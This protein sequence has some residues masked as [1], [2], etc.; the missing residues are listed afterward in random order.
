M[1]CEL[2][3]DHVYYCLFQICSQL[4]TR[5]EKQQASTKE[6]L[7]IVK[8]KY[9][10]KY[11]IQYSHL[12]RTLKFLLK[13]SLCF[14]Q[15]FSN[16]SILSKHVRSHVQSTA[17]KCKVSLSFRWRVVENTLWDSELQEPQWWKMNW[18]S[19]HANYKQLTNQTEDICLL[20]VFSYVLCHELFF[21]LCRMFQIIFTSV[22]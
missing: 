22:L 3:A 8:V 4:S 15:I 16:S 7:D 13:W 1:M 14:C 12:G 19:L 18:F 6:E 11:F 21:C 10:V 9:P 20:P 2:K 5:L 17:C